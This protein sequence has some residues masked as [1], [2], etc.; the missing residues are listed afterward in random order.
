MKFKRTQIYWA[1]ALGLLALGVL[2]WMN[3]G[4][5]VEIAMVNQGNMVQSV[6]TSGHIADV[7]R[8]EVASQSTVPIESILVREGAMVQTG[9]V[10]VRL[11]DDEAQASLRQADAALLEARMRLR[12]IQTIQGPVSEQQLAQ[13]RAADQQAQQELKR[14]QELLQ[15]GFVSPSRLDDVL[16]AAN[17]SK[18]ALL[19]ASAQAQGYQAGGAEVALVEARLEQALAARGVAFARLDQ[20]VLRAPATAMV[21]TRAAEPGD[22]AQAGRSIL[23][24]VGG[25]ETRI[26][27]SVD[28]KNVKFLRLGQNASASADAYLDRPFSAQ[29]FYIAPSVDVQRG[30]IE[31]KL[32]VDPS[33]NYL[34]PDMTVSVEI[35]TAQVANALMLPTD[36]LR[37]DANGALFVLVNQNG[38]A[39]KVSVRAGLQ[40]I[41]TTQITQ[42]LASGDPVILPGST[43]LEGDR[44]RV[45]SERAPLGKTQ[46]VHGLAH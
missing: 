14:S 12:Q 32:R 18:A 15:Q 9:Q 8:T 26:H 44:V 31:L 36:A 38:H 17:T 21:I 35:L 37:R 46:A 42:G 3:R 43:A 30:T 11:R 27:A 1:A 23:T 45:Q 16:R 5:P 19:A 41:G 28:E 6:V 34:R 33:V 2:A 39:K 29:L 4:I 13:A 10:L 40:G 24:L 25:G 22:M 7:A 20:L